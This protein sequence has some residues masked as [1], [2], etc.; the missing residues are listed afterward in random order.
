MYAC[1]TCD[2]DNP[3]NEHILCKDC[4]HAGKG[5]SKNRRQVV[6]KSSKKLP[7]ASL[8]S[9]A[10]SSSSSKG[11]TDYGKDEEV[12]QTDGK[13]HKWQ[14]PIDFAA[15]NSEMKLESSKESKEKALENQPQNN[16]CTIL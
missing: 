11:S 2:Y 12:E 9:S 10:S 3:A 8:S 1:I 5:K 7:E 16:W 6:H 15:L 13:E 4:F 14:E